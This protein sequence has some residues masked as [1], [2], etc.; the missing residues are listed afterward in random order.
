[1]PLFDAYL[2]VDWSA[3]SKPNYGA[4]SIWWSLAL[5]DGK[6][7]K[8]RPSQNVRTRAEARQRLTALLNDLHGAGRR[9]LV[10]FDFPLAYPAGVAQALNCTGTPWQGVWQELARRIVDG[11]DNANNRFIV[12]GDLNR[13]I[14]AATFPFWGHHPA[15]AWANVE[16]HKPAANGHALAERR[17]VEHRV[18]GPQPCW[19]LYGNGA[20]GSQALLGIPVVDALRRAFPESRVWPFETLPATGRV[21]PIVF[22][23]IYPSLFL[24]RGPDGAIKDKLQVEATAAGFAAQ[25]DSGTLP[26]LL[27]A[28][29]RNPRADRMRIITEEGWILGVA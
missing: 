15:H 10:G 2:M 28:P 23:E 3:S 16:R 17:T 7:L 1:M 25:D 14:S 29:D 26:G 20:V 24:K 12:A 21:P 22:A 9:C 4:D 18:R 19:K 13:A 11:A 6:R 8:R 5:R 27:S